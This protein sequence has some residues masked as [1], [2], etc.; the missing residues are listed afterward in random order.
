MSS[1][2]VPDRIQ[3][4]LQR[5]RESHRLRHR[6]TVTALSATECL[7]DGVRCVSFASNDYLGLAHHPGVLKCFQ[8]AANL[9]VGATASALVAGRSSWH[10]QLERRIA[11]FEGTES[12]ILFPSGF[13]ANQ[14]T[15][16]SLVGPDD[17]VFCDRDNHASIIDGCRAAA[18]KMLVY[19]HQALRKL[20]DA[21]QRRRSEF[22]QAFLVTDSVFSMDGVVAPLREL[23]RI[24]EQFNVQVIVDEAHATGVFGPTGRGVCEALGVEEAVQV[25][26]GTLSKAIGALGG[27]V[28]A[29]QPVCDWLWN[30]ARSQFFS[31]A[32]P[33]AVCAAASEALRLIPQ[34][35]ARAER[36]NAICKFARQLLNELGLE[37][38]AGSVGPIVPVLVGDD[39][40]A[41][42]ISETLLQHGFF[43]PAIRPPTVRAGTARLRL[44]L[45]S[46]HSRQQTEDAMRCI[47]GILQRSRV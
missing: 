19:R 25:R 34:D 6:R 37:T 13:A 4:Q 35:V 23:V 3:Q 21:L 31:T 2:N 33:P 38:I 44:S 43:I 42:S 15:L 8:E 11:R 47:H 45:C 9:Q 24:A 22:D 26:I 12:A 14:G 27:F 40:T 41:V 30:S 46:E 7:V 5:L 16:T 39:D 32:L 20:V 10:A 17:C 1:D 18:G 28:A 29:S 36:L